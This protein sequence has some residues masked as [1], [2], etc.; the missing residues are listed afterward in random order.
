MSRLFAGNGL[1]VRQP[2]IVLDVN[3]TLSDLRPLESRF[4]EVGAVAGAAEAW[5]A[6]VLRDGFALTIADARP[7][8]ADTARDAAR[9]LLSRQPLVRG[10]DD[11]V[12]H[13]MEGLGTLPLHDDV[14]PALRKL[15]AA[16]FRVVTLSNGSAEVAHDLLEREGLLDQVERLFSV[17]DQTAWKPAAAAYGYAAAQLNVGPWDMALAACHPW[18]VDG[19]IRAGLRAV[20]VNRDGAAYPGTFTAPTAT[21]T[22]LAQLVD[23]LAEPA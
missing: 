12:E 1:R 6:A 20:W 15:S 2:V 3:E 5:F 7:V 23:V 8:F 16:G 13:V 21:V 11:A 4:A 19:A 10:L 9:A 14:A 18:D 22:D 17:E